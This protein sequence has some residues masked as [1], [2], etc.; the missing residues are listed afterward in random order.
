M[1]PL[2]PPS[3]PMK[4]ALRI[5]CF[6]VFY[7]HAPHTMFVC[8][9]LCMYCA[10]CTYFMSLPVPRLYFHVPRNLSAHTASRVFL[11]E[12][13]F[14]RFPICSQE[15]T[16]RMALLVSAQFIPAGRLSSAAQCVV[17]GVFFQGGGGRISSTTG[18]HIPLWLRGRG[19]NPPSLVALGIVHKAS[20]ISMHTGTPVHCS[21]WDPDQ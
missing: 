11:G 3:L 1:W 4:V 12:Y 2:P 15:E 19:Q 5:F 13:G 7:V 9:L 6:P 18:H 20:T 8:T 21:G 14:G 16:R 17:V 10:H